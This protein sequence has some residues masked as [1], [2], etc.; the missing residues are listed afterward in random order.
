MRERLQDYLD[1]FAQTARNESYSYSWVHHHDG[2]A[3]QTHLV[4][5]IM[6]HGDEVGSLPGAIRTIQELNSGAFS[7]GGRAT[8]FIGNPEAGLQNKRFL[9]SDLNRVFLDSPEQDH[10]HVRARQIMPILNDCDVFI[11]FHQTILKTERPFYIFPWNIDGWAWARALQAAEVWVTR[12][13]GQAFSTGTMCADEYV[14]QQS[15]PGL[16]IELSEKGFSPEAERIA[17]Q[18]MRTAMELCDAI[19]RKDTTLHQ[20]AE[21]KPELTFYH[22]VHR[23]AF[24]TPQHC[25]RAG[26]TNFKEV[27]EGDSLSAEHTPPL[28]APS[29]GML[30]FPKYPPRIS[31]LAQHPKPKEIYRIIDELPGHPKDLYSDAQ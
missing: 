28:H 13:P 5:G 24:A 3:H 26:L 12:H 20:Y 10:E 7:F 2:G 6:V 19:H 29:T 18:S 25:L 22:T 17:Y 8:F 9:D 1:T 11:D 31:G 14:R 4:F 16:T 30:L 23:E 15:K 21:T 27:R